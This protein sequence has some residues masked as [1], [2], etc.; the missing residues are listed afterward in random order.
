ML[1]GRKSSALEARAARIRA[2]LAGRG[3]GDP[4]I[5]TLEVDLSDQGETRR[6][7]AE[8]LDRF[9]AID[10]LILSVVTLGQHGP[11][12]LPDGHELTFATNVMGPFLFNFRCLQFNE[13][14]NHRAPP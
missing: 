13:D 9:P 4:A 1:L 5:Q 6:A 8:A 14:F 11:T 7:A 3:S 12:I 10:G 2:D